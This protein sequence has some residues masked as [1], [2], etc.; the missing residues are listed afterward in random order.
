M[1]AKQRMSIALACRLYTHDAVRFMAWVLYNEKCTI[2]DRMRAA[3][4]LVDRGHGKAQQRIEILEPQVVEGDGETLEDLQAEIERRGL[5]NVIDLIP[6][7]RVCSCE[8]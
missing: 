7:K 1:S 3:E 5:K 8:W 6:T 4:W 2:P